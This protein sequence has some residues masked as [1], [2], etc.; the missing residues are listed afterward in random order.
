MANAEFR[1]TA[2]TSIPA[3]CVEIENELDVWRESIFYEMDFDG[4][5]LDV[6]TSLDARRLYEAMDPWTLVQMFLEAGWT[7]PT[8][9]KE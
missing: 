8:V 1:P 5:D 6:D 2:L 4:L 7:P 3:A 9:D